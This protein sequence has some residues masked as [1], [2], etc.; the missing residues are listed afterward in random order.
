MTREKLKRVEGMCRSRRT[1]H[2]DKAVT[3][4][5]VQSSLRILS[6]PSTRPAAVTLANMTDISWI[7]KL[8]AGLQFSLVN[9]TTNLNN[10]I[11]CRHLGCRS[12]QHRFSPPELRILLL[13]TGTEILVQ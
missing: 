9:N 3:F 12:K 8:A 7:E 4:R 11:E 6:D 2:S 5:S 10:N 1:S 13:S